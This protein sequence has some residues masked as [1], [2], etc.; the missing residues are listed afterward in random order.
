MMQKSHMEH[1]WT[2]SIYA[3]TTENTFLSS[4]LKRKERLPEI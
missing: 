1:F 3:Q 2:Q 4:N